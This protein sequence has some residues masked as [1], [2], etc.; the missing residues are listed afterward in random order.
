MIRFHGCGKLRE[1]ARDIGPSPVRMM[2]VD[3]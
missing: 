3:N 1:L 2:E